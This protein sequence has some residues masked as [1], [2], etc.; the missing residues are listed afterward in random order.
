MTRQGFNWWDDRR[1][2]VA[3]C[4]AMALPLLWPTIPP[5]VDLPGHMGRY[6]VALDIGHSP[7][8]SGYYAFEWRLIGNLGVDL[9]IIPLAKL[10][11][12]EL[13]V[14][15][16]I[17]TIPVLTAAGL[18][19]IAREVHGRVPPT[20]FF[21]L[22]LAYSYPF[23]FGFV[24]FALAMAL[25]L[26]AFAL[27][28]RLARTGHDRLRAI[29]FVPIGLLLW[30][31]HTFGW[32]ALGVLAFSAEVVRQKDKG[33]SLMASGLHAALHCVPLL[34]PAYLMLLW[35]EGNH[36]GGVTGEWFRWHSKFF[37]LKMMLADRWH[38]FDL[39]SVTLLALV[40]VA[41]ARSRW[42]T[43]SRNL[44]ASALVLAGVFAL[45]PRIIFGSAYADMRLAPFVFAIALIA[46]RMRPRANARVARLIAVVALAFCLIRLG[47]TIL[48]YSLYADRHNRALAALDHVPRGARLLS[49]VGVECARAWSTSRLEHFP[50]LATVRKEA[51]G[52]DQWVM[53]GTQL[54]SVRK[55]DAYFF[56]A[57]SSQLVVAQACRGE[58]FRT[59]D[60]S[61]RH[62]PRAAF[63]YVWLI[64][65]PQH[66][67]VYR[68]GLKPVWTNGSDFLYRIDHRVPTPAPVPR[69][70]PKPAA[71]PA[72]A[73]S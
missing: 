56:R 39:A 3:L 27:W 61:L 68:I 19:L 35:R 37:W 15:L 26:L 25:A 42:V 60:A 52:N 38:Y 47:G 23:H 45:L 58:H 18:L 71:A 7:Y 4:L 44:G 11:G 65:P 43:F 34:P 72:K 6:R 13:A 55:P 59:L 14:K 69:F 63:D 51:F 73:A 17:L 53:P 2:L 31:C 16:I 66:D 24:N 10:F 30:V 32:G 29:L 49:F 22:P 5:L 20:A 50:A 57:D 28:L 62:F 8:L 64:D 70:V 48:S 12:L 40:V 1:F 54:L 21:A 41:A 67:P 36:A 9:L 46:I 33:R